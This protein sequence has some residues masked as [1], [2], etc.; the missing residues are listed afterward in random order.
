MS[1]FIV[2]MGSGEREKCSHF[3][4]A[5]FLSVLGESLR[6][7]SIRSI[8]SLPRLNRSL[9]LNPKGT[10]ISSFC[11]NSLS[12]ITAL[13]KKKT[14]SFQ[15]QKCV[16]CIISFCQSLATFTWWMTGTIGPLVNKA[17]SWKQKRLTGFLKVNQRCVWLVLIDVLII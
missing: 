12:W 16:W 6:I 4:L 15:I 17:A 10:G 5:P 2:T 9:C 1:N 7:T 3:H 11:P 14:Q 8:Y 13:E